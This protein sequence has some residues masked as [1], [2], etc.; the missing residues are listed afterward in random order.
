M[1]EHDNLSRRRWLARVSVPALAT[2]GAS[3]AS[4]KAAAEEPAPGDDDKLAG[5]RIYNVRDYG[6]KGDGK[7]L[8]TAAIQSAID[9][10]YHD[11]GGKVLIPAG[12]FLSGTLELKS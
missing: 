8:D 9:A 11:K 3:I 5:A 4:I 1:N 6:A 10:C 12:D 7:T 2:L